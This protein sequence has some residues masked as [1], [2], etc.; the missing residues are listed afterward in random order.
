M[1]YA[2]N[3]MEVDLIHFSGA[4]SLHLM[5]GAL[6]WRAKHLG[7]PLIS[8]DRGPRQGRWVEEAFRR[9]G[10]RHSNVFLVP[11]FEAQKEYED[12][13]VPKEKI[14]LSPN[15]YDPKL[16][17][18]SSESGYS[19]RGWHRQDRPFRI[20][21]VS[22]LWKDKDPMTM[23]EA[24]CDLSHSGVVVELMVVG[25]GLLKAEVKNRL[26]QDQVAVTFVEHMTQEKLANCY[27][28]SDVFLLTSLGEGWNCASVEAMASGLP[29]VASNVR[30]VREAVGDAGILV[31]PGKPRL[32]ADAL[33]LIAKDQNV[34]IDYR[35]RGIARSRE[36][37]WDA[38]VLKMRE[39][40]LSCL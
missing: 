39:L 17:Y 18:P 32:F 29:V 23:A 2:I 38:V 14:F 22:R 35:K 20:L 16:F 13:G 1:I 27:R 30:G 10:L 3:K 26:L 24:V 6:A 7:I 8:H 33:R 34:A 15:G 40:Y 12:M 21:V 19:D 31:P 37:T 9:Y 4:G 11:S 28:S 36:Y 5:L 25:Q